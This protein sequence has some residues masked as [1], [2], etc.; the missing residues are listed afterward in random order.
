[1]EGGQCL[2]VAHSLLDKD[3]CTTLRARSV[4]W[5]VSRAPGL[6]V[7]GGSQSKLCHV[8]GI[9]L[10]PAL[11]VV[12]TEMLPPTSAT[13]DCRL[14]DCSPFLSLL[15][16]VCRILIQ[17]CGCLPHGA[18]LSM[19]SLRHMSSSRDDQY[20]LGTSSASWA[21]AVMGSKMVQPADSAETGWHHSALR[22]PQSWIAGYAL[23]LCVSGLMNLSGYQWSA[24]TE[25][26][27]PTRSQMAGPPT[28]AA[29]TAHMAVSLLSLC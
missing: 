18:G 29:Q 27:L 4:C 3:S 17:R 9:P 23:C 1:M 7:D 5:E 11:T 2:K 12:T 25:Q 6:P 22:A 26:D 16:E 14:P 20:G 13:K 19:L 8:Q 24:H 21:A 28:P 15:F 10:D